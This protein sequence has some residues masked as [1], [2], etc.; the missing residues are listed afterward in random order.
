M[1]SRVREPPKA[2]LAAIAATRVTAIVVLLGL[3]LATFAYRRALEP[4]YGSAPTNLHLSKIVWASCILGSF[5]PSVPLSPAALGLGL[6][7]YALPHSSYWFAVFTGRLGDPI[8]GPVATHLG[9]LM[10][11]LSLGVAVVKALQVGAPVEL[12]YRKDDPSA[13]QSAMTLP[14]CATAVNAL[15][16]LWPAVPFIATAPESQIFVQLGTLCA[17][18]WAIE[19]FLPTI[20]PKPLVQA[21]EPVA[22]PASATSTKGKKGKKIATEKPAASAPPQRPIADAETASGSARLRLA[23][24]PLFPLLS[25]TILQPSTLPKP[26]LEPYQHPSYPLRILSSVSSPYSAVVVVGESQGPTQGFGTMDHLRYLRA[27]HSLLGGVWVGP[28]VQAMDQSYVL[29]DEAG[30]PLGDTIYSAFILQEAARLIVKKP[31]NTDP[32]NALMIG[33]G[34]GVAA[35]SFMRHSLD[36]TIV[37]IDEAVYD[38]AHRF[39]GLPTPAPDRLFIQD[40]RTWVRNR[41]LTLAESTVDSGSAQFD[42]VVHDCFS[43][44]TVPGHLYTQEFWRDLKAIVSPDGVVAVNFA[45]T[46]VSDSG[47]AVVH[48]LYESFPQCRAFYDGDTVDPSHDITSEFVNWVIFCTP[49]T[50]TIEFRRPVESDYL[51]SYLRRHVFS[52]LPEREF[53]VSVAIKAIPEDK[54]DRFLL[55]DAGNPL[56]EW[57][58]KE[59]IG[60]WKIMRGVLPDVFWETY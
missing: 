40:A 34:T 44:G 26:L 9:V 10:P 38:A 51:G 8:W 60:H 18:A 4:L 21:P 56:G 31:K 22:E 3:S 41:S 45:G 50:E 17:F 25:S 14:V 36:T 49:S 55:K 35:T 42:I 32:E 28:K 24:I 29:K 43:G 30:Q 6:L 58:Q 39:F 20:R 59:A 46:L 37:E 33:L 11:I 7:L 12:P 27:G 52:K 54:R 13:P 47:K 15:Q 5:A 19:P 16:G 1:A 2:S 48:T 57:Q 53:D 23:L